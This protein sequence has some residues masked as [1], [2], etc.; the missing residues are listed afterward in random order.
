MFGCE[1]A[2]AFFASRRKRSTNCSVVRGALVQD[3][4]RDAPAE[5]LV[6]GEVDVRH[7]AGAKLAHDLVAAIEKRAD[8]R[9]RD[10]HRG[11]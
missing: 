7:P 1:S 9:V 8:E 11:Q 4:D 2:A 6:L 10:G 3:L 5:L